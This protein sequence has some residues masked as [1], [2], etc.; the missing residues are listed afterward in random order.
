MARKAGVD[1]AEIGAGPPSPD[2]G[3]VRDA[4]RGVAR[5]AASP[6]GGTSKPGMPPMS[7]RSEAQGFTVGTAPAKRRWVGCLPPGAEPDGALPDS[8]PPVTPTDCACP[9]GC[10]DPEMGKT[11]PPTSKSGSEAG[12]PVTITPRGNI[13]ETP[14]FGQ[15]VVTESDS[16]RGGG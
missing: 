8:L 13:V 7:T 9:A 15:R 14:Q 6:R 12:E 1:Q 5:G 10:A 4:K 2:G 16:S 3:G 11:A